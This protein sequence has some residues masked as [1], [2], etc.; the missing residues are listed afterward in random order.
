MTG[1]LIKTMSSSDHPPS[2]MDLCSRQRAPGT[3][4]HGGPGKSAHQIPWTWS[5]SF[6]CQ[7]R[8]MRALNF[9][10]TP[11]PH[12]YVI[13]NLF[14][15]LGHD[16]INDNLRK[17][18]SY[19]NSSVPREHCIITPDRKCSSSR[20]GLTCVSRAQQG[21]GGWAELSFVLSLSGLDRLGAAWL[22]SGW[23]V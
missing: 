7:H 6:H 11:H 20:A 15:Q 21:G 10:A 18:T 9:P 16:S 23:S 3:W 12:N 17:V 8:H 14:L 22:C 19:C 4:D 1:P 13:S 2:G 5:Q